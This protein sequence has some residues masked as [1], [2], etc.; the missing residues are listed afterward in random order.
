MIHSVCNYIATVTTNFQLSKLNSTIE[1]SK[2]FAW[3][4]QAILYCDNMHSLCTSDHHELLYRC[5]HEHAI[6]DRMFPCISYT[7]FIQ[8]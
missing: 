3:T 7:V 8:P 1:I 5:F 4:M 2:Y 6:S